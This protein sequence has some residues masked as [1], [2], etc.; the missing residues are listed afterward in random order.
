MN[1]KCKVEDIERCCCSLGLWYYNEVEENV[2]YFTQSMR[3]NMQIVFAQLTEKHILS[4]M[5]WCLKM[6]EDFMT[7]HAV[8]EK[9]LLSGQTKIL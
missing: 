4:N 1:I 7:G 8:S 9:C 3:K 2:Q 6:E 5:S